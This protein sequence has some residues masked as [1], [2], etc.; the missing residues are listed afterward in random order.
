LIF[1]NKRVEEDNGHEVGRQ[2]RGDIRKQGR[3]KDP[4][5]DAALLK[6]EAAQQDKGASISLRT[7]AGWQAIEAARPDRAR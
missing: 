6:I 5:R 3:V 1:I 2:E 4:T 7:T